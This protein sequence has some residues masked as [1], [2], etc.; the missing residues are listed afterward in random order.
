M[1]ENLFIKLRK[2]YYTHK[3]DSITKKVKESIFGVIFVL[4]KDEE[5]FELLE[6]I[7]STF[8]FLEFM[9]FPFNP[10]IKSVWQNDNITETI[11]TIFSYLS[12]LTYI[13]NRPTVIYLCGLY[14]SILAITLV[15]I[16]I[17]YVSYSFS[18]KYFTATWPLYLLRTVAKIFVTGLFMP[19]LEVN[20][21]IFHC[22]RSDDGTQWVNHANEQLVCFTPIHFL[23]MSI[24]FI[25]TIIFIVI[26]LCV[27]LTF[28]ENSE[29]S[30]GDSAKENSRADF[31]I[32]ISKVV[33]TSIS[34]FFQDEKFQWFV[35]IINFSFSVF[36]VVKMYI[37]RPYYN[38]NQ[39]GRVMCLNGIYMWSNFMLLICKVFSNYQFEGGFYIWLIGCPIVGFYFWKG[40]DES[41]SVLSKGIN[42]CKTGEEVQ[43]H[44]RYFLTVC[45]HLNQRDE[46]NMTLQGYIFNHSCSDPLCGICQ[47]KKQNNISSQNSS[48]SSINTS[49]QNIKKY[50]YDFAEN[51]YIKEISRYP[52]STSLRLAYAMFL[53]ERKNDKALAL[54][55]LTFAEKYNPL[56]DEEFIIYRYSKMINDENERLYHSSGAL[57]EQFE[58]EEELDVVSS[59]A[60]DSHFR[61]CL[62]NIKKSAELYINFWEKIISSSTQDLTT[63]NEMAMNINAANKNIE[64]HWKN[65][66]DIKPNDPKAFKI[67]GGYVKNVLNNKDKGNELMA[68][69]FETSDKKPNN[70]GYLNFEIDEEYI[71]LAKEGNAFIVCSMEDDKSFGNILKCSK[72]TM[73]F[74]GFNEKEIMGYKNIKNVFLECYNKSILS[75][76]KNELDKNIDTLIQCKQYLMFLKHKSNKPQPT[77]AV[78]RKYKGNYFKE[79]CFVVIFMCDIENRENLKNYIKNVY[80]VI[81]QDLKVKYLT[82]SALDLLAKLNRKVPD[83][84]GIFNKLFPEFE[85]DKTNEND[86]VV[87]Q[88]ENQ[89]VILNASL[90]CKIKIESLSGYQSDENKLYI[91]K[92]QTIP[93]NKISKTQHKNINIKPSYIYPQLSLLMKKN[94]AKNSNDNN[95]I[96]INRDTEINNNPINPQC[97]VL[98]FYEFSNIE[99][100]R[101]PNI[102]NN[103]TSLLDEESEDSSMT[104]KVDKDNKSDNSSQSDKEDYSEE[105]KDKILPLSKSEQNESEFLLHNKQLYDSLTSEEFKKKL[106]SLKNY[107]KKVSF[108]M[109]KI[110]KN[111][112]EKIE[113]FQPRICDILKDK[114]H[115]LQITDS[116][117][118]N[119]GIDYTK[120]QGASFTQKN[121]VYS[122]VQ[123]LG[124]ISF[125]MLIVFLVYSVIEYW[126]NQKAINSKENNF[127]MIN[128]SFDSLKYFQLCEIYL[129]NIIISNE[130]LYTNYNGLTKEQ[131]ITSSLNHINQYIEALVDIHQNLTSRSKDLEKK[132]SELFTKQIVPFMITFEDGNRLMVNFSFLHAFQMQYNI[133]LSILPTNI[134]EITYENDYVYEY[135]YNN[136]NDFFINELQSIDYF[137][138]LIDKRIKQNIIEDSIV[139]VVNFL[140]S[141]IGLFLIYKRITSIELERTKML[142]SFYKIP[143]FYLK[144]LSNKSKIFIQKIEKYI[145]NTEDEENQNKSTDEDGDGN[146]MNSGLNEKDELMLKTNTN[147]ADMGIYIPPNSSN[148]KKGSF[149]KNYTSFPKTFILIG[150]ILI[151]FAVSFITNTIS[152]SH[153]RTLNTN[154]YYNSYYYV[155]ATS[156]YN[157]V[158]G[159]ITNSSKEIFTLTELNVLNTTF[160]DFSQLQIDIT[161]SNSDSYE[162]FNKYLV[163]LLNSIQ[164]GDICSI[165]T[166]NQQ[167]EQCDSKLNYISNFGGDIILSAYYENLRLA[168]EDAYTLQNETDMNKRIQV[169]NGEH[170]YYMNV[171]IEDYLKGILD[172][173]KNELLVFIKDYLNKQKSLNTI[174]LIVFEIIVFCVFLFFWI[175]FLISLKESIFQTQ[176]M[177]DVIPEE[178]LSKINFNDNPTQITD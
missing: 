30:G 175:P 148:I 17:G 57:A 63:L 39:M 142:K 124:Y 81:D 107:A 26:S 86:K 72:T 92:L 70:I 103:F 27:A 80:F 134:K 65:M 139:C 47:L 56:F 128:I 135:M 133:L 101:N 9:I 44:L 105:I 130:N 90:G 68:I 60:Y 84:Y 120:M 112:I 151:Y 122:S 159:K 136:M 21:S 160:D 11:S 29:N 15:L 146:S 176:M 137:Y 170:Y 76:I 174:L 35:I 91:I 42:L 140:I 61:L 94:I 82:Q 132:H 75:F 109:I 173:W 162:I 83:D 23:H 53:Y 77:Y 95:I 119:K 165:S 144:N 2:D 156:M 10:E 97:K 18:R 32:Q 43:R 34:T 20:L 24:S 157:M 100:P 28:F 64:I 69:G 123:N 62:H 113:H 171:L 67:Y 52:N 104:S 158:I 71:H 25:V 88:T 118:L 3:S 8:E 38:F 40:T 99:K 50:L 66:L 141:I 73:K 102:F 115:T 163:N 172:L 19:L 22:I 138:E 59:I 89:Y 149:S 116:L 87:I 167:I 5:T 127:D 147:S 58:E 4:L 96:I 46:N 74:G 117:T 166:V 154:F 131:Y 41:K 153:T 55:Q 78:F 93:T 33:S 79:K 169:L 51:I 31:A 36:Q 14:A 150:F 45:E 161:E 37:D 168:L 177:I 13:E 126:L 129:R 12:L 155:N 125:F 7:L 143:K 106:D 164:K 111:E 98:K 54:Q 178:I 110:K 145:V 121:K 1:E 49:T 6:V 85:F 108:Y 48:N 16:N 114:K 152:S